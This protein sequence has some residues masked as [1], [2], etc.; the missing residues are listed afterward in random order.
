MMEQIDRTE[1]T[2]TG[3]LA[4]ITLALALALILSAMTACSNDAVAGSA[5]VRVFLTDAPL[6]LTTVSAVN[7]TVTELSLHA[8]EDDEGNSEKLSLIGDEPWTV[9]LL[10]Y[11]D[12]NVVLMAE[13]DILAGDYD[14]IRLHVS[15][16]ELLMDDDGDPMSPDVVVPIFNPSGKVDI[17]AAFLVS[18]GDDLSIT[19]DFDAQLSVQVNTTGGQ[20]PYILR[21]VIN[22]VGMN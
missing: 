12:G 13:G 3:K 17:P 11:Q 4:L 15:A 20:H 18:A 10:D 2:A 6:D 19:L 21:P 8:A 1:T 14:K 22:L 5:T 9:N 7:V 16:A